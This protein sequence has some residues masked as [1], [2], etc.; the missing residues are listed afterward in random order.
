MNPIF[1]LRNPHTDHLELHFRTEADPSLFS[2]QIYIP[3][4]FEKKPFTESLLRKLNSQILYKTWAEKGFA[5]R[6]MGQDLDRVQT[7]QSK[8]LQE[9][10][11][12]GMV[13]AVGQRVIRSNLRTLLSENASLG[14]FKAL[15]MMFY[16]TMGFTFLEMNKNSFE[17]QSLFCTGQSSLYLT[18][19]YSCYYYLCTYAEDIIMKYYY[20]YYDFLIIGKCWIVF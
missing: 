15:K 3:T 9:N 8:I 11:M 5:D 14:K 2:K 10:G 20:Y 17:D 1:F 4:H 12:L 19:M 16:A 13:L 18:I 6:L 7:K